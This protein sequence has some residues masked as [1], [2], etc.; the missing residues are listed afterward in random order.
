MEGGGGAV[1]VHCGLPAFVLEFI[2]NDNTHTHTNT[3]THT[4][5]YVHTSLLYYPNRPTST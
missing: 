1:S 4:H 2:S 5:V 3:Y